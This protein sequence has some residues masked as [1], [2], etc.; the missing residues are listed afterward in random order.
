[1]TC[2]DIGNDQTRR[3]IMIDRNAPKALP[4]IPRPGTLFLERSE[5][6][7]RIYSIEDHKEVTIDEIPL[8]DVGSPEKINDDCLN[9]GQVSVE[10]A[11]LM[12][13]G[14]FEFTSDLYLLLGPMGTNDRLMLVRLDDRYELH[15][16]SVQPFQE[17]DLGPQPFEAT[18]EDEMIALV[19]V[20][21]REH[22]H[23]PIAYRK[24]DENQWRLSEA[25]QVSQLE[26]LPFP[27][28]K[29][30]LLLLAEAE[31]LSHM[32]DRDAQL[33]SVAV[34][35]LCM[36]AATIAF[37][38]G[39]WWASGAAAILAI[40]C[41]VLTRPKKSHIW[42]CEICRKEGL[43]FTAR[44]SSRREARRSKVEHMR[45]HSAS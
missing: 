4:R 15:D 5:E 28:R 10:R 18:T 20:R 3:L 45:S 41:F 27:S 17:I 9:W 25:L 43:V 12:A 19:A 23:N 29:I 36:G 40:V 30:G 39:V 22:G 11:G 38:E 32:R 42:S 14:Y 13:L 44:L 21:A 37:L 31:H 8:L 2:H 35:S 16:T 26:D 24:V 33:V 34:V 6:I 7:L 1:M